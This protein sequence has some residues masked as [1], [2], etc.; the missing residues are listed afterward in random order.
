MNDAPNHLPRDLDA[1][2]YLDALNAGDLEAVAEVWERASL[3]AELEQM[4]VEIDGALLVEARG[5][6]SPLRQSSGRRPRSWALWA[7]VAGCLASACLIAFL[8]WPRRDGKHTIPS[9]G[10]NQP[11]QRASS[12]PR[13]DSVGLAP[14]LAARRNLNETEMPAFAWPYENTLSTSSPLDLPD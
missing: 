4:L 11:V 12:Q 9:P 10:K 14:L 1:L 6:A 8:A 2:R 7:G 5:D 13:D 3:D